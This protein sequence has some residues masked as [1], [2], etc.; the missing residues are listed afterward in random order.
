VSS[1]DTDITTTATDDI[2]SVL[3]TAG[4]ERTMIIHHPKA[5]VQFAGAAWAGK[6]LPTTPGSITWAYKELASVDYIEYSTTQ[7]NNMEGKNCNYYTRLAGL[8]NTFNGKSPNGEWFDVVRTIDWTEA[9]M[10]EGVYGALSRTP[11]IPYTDP[12]ATVI[13]N[14]VEAVLK[15]GV[16][17]TAYKADPAPT[18]TVPKVA[19]VSIA[20]RAN[21][22]LPDVN[23]TAELAG[24]IHKTIINGNVSV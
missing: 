12:G 1:L 4:Y 9:R 13:Q 16:T 22:L 5:N 23:F 2:A 15:Q 17:N 10:Q 14:E 7:I 6:G 3:Q 20:N 19:T 24:A 11:K 21:R 18:V 8:S